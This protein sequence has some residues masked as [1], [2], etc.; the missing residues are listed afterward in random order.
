[1]IW[2]ATALSVPS[3]LSLLGVEKFLN[4]NFPLVTPRS[5]LTIVNGLMTIVN[6][7]QL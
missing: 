1:V 2:Q 6:P 3:L 5:L 7:L 4:C